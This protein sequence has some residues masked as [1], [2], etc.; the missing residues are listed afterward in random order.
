LP[1]FP[2]L[3]ASTMT[4]LLRILDLWRA[5]IF[6]LVLGVV[7]ALIAFGTSIALMM[8]SGSLLVASFAGAVVALPAI[9]Q[10]IGPT[11]VVS[12]YLERLATH[13]AT[14]RALT[15]LR[16]WFFRGLAER[17]AGGLGFRSAGDVL[18]RLVNDI[19]ALDGLYLRILVPFASLL[20]LIP[21]F[22]VVPWRTSPPLAIGLVAVLVC[23]ALVLPVW[24]SRAARAAAVDLTTSVAS[25]R[26]IC[27]DAL[28]GLREVRAFGAEGRMIATMQAI[29]AGLLQAQR[30]LAARGALANAG[31]FLAGQIALLLIL[32]L[33]GGSTGEAITLVFLVIAGFEA[34]GALPRA[35]AYAGAASQSA[36]RVIDA[37]EGPIPVPDPPHPAK[38][39][40]SNAIRIENLRFRW[41]ADRPLVFDGLSFEIPS[42]CR[43]ALLGPS[44]AGKSSLAALL[45]KVAV[46]E[47][48]QIRLGG[49]D[50][51]SLTADS[52]RARIAWLGQA[53]HLFDD[54]IRANLLLGRPDATDAELWAALDQAAIGDTVRTL[55]HG[56]DTWVGE[57]GTRFSGGQARRLVL[58]RALL[59][60]APILI[61]DEPCNG[62][63]ADAER[64]FLETLNQVAP[65][66]TVILIVH[67]LTGAERLDRIYRLAGGRALAATA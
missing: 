25:L 65:E 54:S 17:S 28:S 49:A 3:P 47:S 19:E 36:Q 18:A 58:A 43:V 14:F 51:A 56:L 37:A 26:V 64:S 52:V 27:L 40:S 12:R 59:S 4:P 32:L 30:S 6:W 16:V 45:L 33:A 35:G 42:G 2:L 23:A 55:P 15:D 62:L 41:S 9:L 66:R 67:R 39:P 57:G 29:E 8:L 53:T 63:D 61:L 31:A 22:L 38:A 1:Y 34:V 48:G 44:G 10:I 7:I 21:V 13:E 11:R 46:P 50:I 60:H 24:M 5:Q 20:L